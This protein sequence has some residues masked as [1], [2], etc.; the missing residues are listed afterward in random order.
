MRL[1]TKGRYA[2]TAMLDLALRS[3]N[4]PVTA[5]DIS[6]Q[7]KIPLSYL[8]QLFCKL[9]QHH[10]VESVHGPGGG[11]SLARMADEIS[12]ADIIQAVDEPVDA[13]QCHGKLNCHDGER[14]M[15]HD[16]WADLNLEINHY[17]ASVSLSR[18]AASQ[19]DRSR[20]VQPLKMARRCHPA[21]NQ[22]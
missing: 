15:T 20:T 5:A 6:K 10:L 17:L 3:H 11:Y 14:C 12:M 16:L 21:A 2:V 1:T 13:T 4:G 8:V 22:A 7:Q 19:L 18:L 9:R